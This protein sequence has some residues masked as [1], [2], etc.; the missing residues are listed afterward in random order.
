MRLL[1][2][3]RAAA[4]ALLLMSF[5]S[6]SRSGAPAPA[7]KPV[8][9]HQT[10]Q[11]SASCCANH[12][13]AD[14]AISDASVYQLGSVWTDM[15]GNTVRMASLQGKVRV[16]AMIFTNCVYVCPRITT[17][18]RAIAAALPPS[19]RD[20]VG[21]VL[22]SIDPERDSLQALVNY[23]HKMELD[24]AQWLLVRGDDSSVRELAAVLGVKYKKESNGDFS[25][26][27]LITVLNRKGEIMHRQEGLGQDPRKTIA[28]VQS[29][30]MAQ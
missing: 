26:S 6:C 20:D 30:T 13:G 24:T 21:F 28:M 23:A 27:V 18:M 8:S 2:L 9:E 17:D 25:H 7:H 29:L 22:F 4:A 10:H 11:Q 14:T 1:S 3:R 16:V 15:H 19:V 5:W 12:E